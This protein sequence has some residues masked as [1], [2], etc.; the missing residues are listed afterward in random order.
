MELVL[1]GGTLLLYIGILI[2]TII[3][4]IA[5]TIVTQKTL[6]KNTPSYL[7]F[8]A[9]YITCSILQ[10][11]LSVYCDLNPLPRSIDSISANIFTL[12][13][14]LVFCNFFLSIIESKRFKKFLL[15]CLFSFPTFCLYYWQKI[16]SFYS[17]PY[18]LSVIEAFCFLIPCFFYFYEVF[19]K[20]P[21]QNLSRQSTFWITTGIL[22]YFI[23]LIPCF[24][25][26]KFLEDDW[27]LFRNL[28]LIGFFSTS[29]FYLLLIKGFLC[30]NTQIP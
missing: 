16:N 25:I 13:E 5:L 7:K 29:L 9:P 23:T 20:P 2:M 6:K 4:M 8:F 11:L 3:G 1:R 19:T 27:F 22:F 10:T 17:F 26:M 15:F 30:K 21:I 28:G 24:L 18:I 14:F 12:L